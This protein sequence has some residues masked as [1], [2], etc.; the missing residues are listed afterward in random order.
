MKKKK[1][2]I[3][4]QDG[5]G[6]AE[7]MSVLIGKN[8]DTKKFDVCFC[9]VDRK[10]ESS[11]VDFI[12]NEMRTKRIH[13]KNPFQL[14]WKMVTMILWEK[15]HAVFSSV[16]NLNNKYLAF[17]WLYPKVK[18][19]IRCDNYLYTYTAKQQKMIAKLYPKADWIIAQTQEMKDELVM[20]LGIDEKK[21]VVLQNPIDKQTIDK[22]V[23]E[24]ISPYPDNGKKHFVAVGRFN[25][26]KG[27][28][29]LIEA[30]INV[31]NKRKDVDLYIVG[32]NTLENGEIYKNLVQ[33]AKDN[34]VEKLVHCVGY[35]DNPYIF[36]KN[37]DCFV[38]SSR[39]EGLPNVLIESLY[40]G[41][42]AAAFKCIPVIERIIKDGVTGFCA[43]KENVESL[44]G[45][46]IRALDIGKIKSSYESNSIEDFTKLFDADIRN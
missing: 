6:G 43:E 28:D 8:L 12:P 24:D 3:F 7:R 39:W 1:V 44:T 38:L 34:K 36:V 25:K 11:I 23:A 33:K 41:T 14:M 5:V 21:V 10:S 32:D 22:K 31:Y 9:L 40:L 35:K 45:A 13:N 4:V 26:Q 2:L 19:I 20:Q 27:F 42:P 30:F 15:P 16:I 37:A 46:M 18:V 29:M 17:C